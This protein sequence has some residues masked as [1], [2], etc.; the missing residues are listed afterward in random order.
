MNLL[1]GQEVYWIGNARICKGTLVR[2]EWSDVAF[3][4]VV[5]DDEGNIANPSQVF[6]EKE[7]AEEYLKE[8]IGQL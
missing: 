7:D 1:E 6:K 4:G 5:K 2:E 8:V 3:I